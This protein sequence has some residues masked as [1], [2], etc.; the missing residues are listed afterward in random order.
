[1]FDYDY[2]QKFQKISNYIEFFRF[3]KTKMSENPPDSKKNTET[4]PK[5]A[6]NSRDVNLRKRLTKI[7]HFENLKRSSK[8]VC[9]FQQ[10][11]S[12][13]SCVGFWILKSK[14]PLAVSRSM[15]RGKFTQRSP[16]QILMR[17]C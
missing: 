3:I 17:F 10:V 5:M 14:S 8:S 11:N 6:E 7:Q 4:G 12:I 15:L 1:M 9:P 16:P 2:F 13:N